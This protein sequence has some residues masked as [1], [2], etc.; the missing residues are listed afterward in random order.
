[1]AL[2]KISR[3]LLNT[4]VSD[5]SDATAITID[6]SERVGIGGSPDTNYQFHVQSAGN[7]Y[8]KITT[9]SNT[10]R[11]VFEVVNDAGGG[12]VMLAYGANNTGTFS[13]Y[14]KADR[15]FITSSRDLIVNVVDQN[16]PPTSH[17]FAL[18]TNG[19]D[20]IRVQNNGNVGIGETAP[21]RNLVVKSTSTSAAIKLVNSSS[22]ALS[23]INFTNANVDFGNSHAT[24][25]LTLYTNNGNANM[26]MSDTGNLYLT[27]GND[28]RIKLSDSGIAG[29]S[30]SNN[31]VHIRG[32]ND[33]LKLMAAGNGGLIYEEDGTEHLSIASGGQLKFNAGF[34]SSGKAYGVRA[35][36]NFN[37]TGTVAIRD[38][39]NVSSITDGG[40]GDYSVNFTTAMPDA[41]YA[42]L[43][44]AGHTSASNLI[45]LTVNH[46]SGSLPATGSVHVYTAYANT[47]AFDS[48]N[49]SVAIVR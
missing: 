18:R 34:G 30:D 6:S 5:S 37:G 4:G 25:N 39:G 13:G 41:N 15:T 17:F 20:R 14:D 21:D 24:G 46:V 47:Y 29:E 2:P 40:T 48:L 28:R 22:S 45:A 38:N 43:G 36:V 19:L 10:G 44:T 3:G 27:G 1:M 33:F 42:I 26:I 8:S 49:V 11:G 16:V 12:I 23:M 35:W 9:S 31:T 7:T 32:D